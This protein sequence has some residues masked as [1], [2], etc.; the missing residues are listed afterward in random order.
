MANPLITGNQPHSLGA[1]EKSPHYHRSSCGA[2]GLVMN[3]K[4]THYTY[5]AL[6]WFLGIED[7]IALIVEEI[8]RVWEAAS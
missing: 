5:M 7:R 6:E 3:N 8:P 2:K 4:T 1:I